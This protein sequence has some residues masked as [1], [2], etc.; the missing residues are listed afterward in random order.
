MGRPLALTLELARYLLPRR[1]WPEKG[2]LFPIVLMLE[3]LEAC[4]L[5]CAGCGRVREYRE[6]MDRRLSVDE[7]LRAAESA[8]A[9]VVSLSG[10]EPLL[11]RGIADLVRGLIEQKRWVFLCTN[12]LLLREKIEKFPR[13][14]RLCFVVHLDGTEGVHDAVAGRPGVFREALAA[15]REAL[16]GGYRVATNTTVFHGSDVEDLRRLFRA[17]TDLGV[18]G[19]MISPGYAYESVPERELF[20]RREEATKVFRALLDR[21]E[22]LP[23]LRQP[24]VPRFPPGEAGVRGVRGLGCPHLHRARL[25][26]PLLPPCGPPHP[27]P[28]GGAG[29][30]ALAALRSGAG[31]ALRGVHA[32][33]GVR[34]PKRLG[35]GEPAMGAPPEVIVV[36]ALRTELLFVRGP[37]AALGVGARSQG[38]LCAFLARRRP[39]GVVIVGYAGGLHADLRPGALVLPD[40]VWDQKGAVRVSGELLAR[41]RTRLPHAR[42]GPLFTDERLTPLAAK[43]AFEGRALAVDMET[44]HLAREL[45]AR[46]IP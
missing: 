10:G 44:S 21:K 46:G 2:K 6:V 40:L 38:R 27:G 16:A 30:G 1:R 11:H 36:A 22:R 13:H 3:P 42:V 15:I 34:A 9:P 31:P 12:G 45:S 24:P 26:R 35:G 25:A 37:K 43:A 17:L 32:P 4:N 39:Q 14:K 29:S 41:A 23:P 18:E 8:G 20:L 28:R 33:R 19:L 5:R 7:A